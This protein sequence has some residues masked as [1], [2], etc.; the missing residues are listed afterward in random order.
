MA[1]DAKTTTSRGGS[2]RR[3]AEKRKDSENGVAKSSAKKRPKSPEIRVHNMKVLKK[4]SAMRRRK[5]AKEVLVVN[6]VRVVK[7]TAILR[8]CLHGLVSVLLKSSHSILPYSVVLLA[9]P[10]HIKRE[11]L[12]T[13]VRPAR[14]GR[15]LLFRG[16]GCPNLPFCVLVM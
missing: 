15:T 16:T 11:G 12:R 10:S 3:E 14:L 8:Q 2:V 1:K 7:G 4:K 13:L 6:V 9:R 5:L